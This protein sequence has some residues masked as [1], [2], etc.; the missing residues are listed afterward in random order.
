MVAIGNYNYDKIID[1]SAFF[2]T[3]YVDADK[4]STDKVGY[5]A[6]AKML[7]YLSGN[8]FRPLDKITRA[9]AITYLYNIYTNL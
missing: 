4:I 8:T 3:G 9:E 7:K 1:N 5:I 6:I 2:N